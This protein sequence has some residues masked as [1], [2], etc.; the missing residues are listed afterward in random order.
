GTIGLT[1]GLHA[2]DVEYRQGG[3][4]AS[5]YLDW[6]LPGD[7]PGATNPPPTGFNLIPSTAFSATLDNIVQSGTGSLT[8]ANANTYSGTTTVSAGQLIVAHD[9]ALGPAGQTAPI[10]PVTVQ[11]GGTLGFAG[12]ITFTTLKL[13]T[14]NGAGAN[15]IGALANIGGDNILADVI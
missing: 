5:M 2:I 15:G 10:G 4:G 8:L 3:G 14:I 13:I 9:D 12:G 1:P 6:N 11:S 7:T